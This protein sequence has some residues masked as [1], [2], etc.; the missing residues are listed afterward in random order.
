M[1]VKNTRLLTEIAAL[2]EAKLNVNRDLNAPAAPAQDPEAEESQDRAERERITTYIQLQA[3]EIEALRME[4]TMLRRK[5][6]PAITIPPTL[7]APPSSPPMFPPIPTAKKT[8]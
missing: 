3:R 4:I 7:P 8:S 1:T 5:E 6:A 2:T